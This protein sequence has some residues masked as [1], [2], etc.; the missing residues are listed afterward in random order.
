[1][2]ITHKPLVYGFLL[3][4]GDD[5]YIFSSNKKE[6]REHPYAIQPEEKVRHR[7][8][9]RAADYHTLADYYRTRHHT[10]K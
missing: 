6:L 5:I 4:V 8:V 3:L 2:V 7:M 1:M 9:K 10:Y